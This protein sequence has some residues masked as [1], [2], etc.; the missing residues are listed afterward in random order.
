MDYDHYMHVMRI[1]QIAHY[2]GYLDYPKKEW[3]FWVHPYNKKRELS[4]RFL[5]FYQNIRLLPDKFF[6]YYRMSVSSFDEL[7]TKMRPYITKQETRFRSP[8]SPEE[9]LTL[10]IR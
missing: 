10:T 5:N 3:Q 1:V 9:R 6:T 7:L 8:I 4:K 2:Y